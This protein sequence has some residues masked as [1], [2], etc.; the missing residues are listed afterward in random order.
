MLTPNF[1]ELHLSLDL[2]SYKV[3]ICIMI[4]I[5]VRMTVGKDQEDGASFS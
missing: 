4:M 1:D 5:V 3:V 2:I